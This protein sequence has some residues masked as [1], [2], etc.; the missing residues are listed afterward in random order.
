M[1]V[2][3]SR[4]WM[5]TSPTFGKG[6][7]LALIDDGCK[8]SMPEWSQPGSQVPKVLIS[9]D[10]VDG[11]DNPQHEGKGYHGSTIGIPSSVNFNGML[12][13]AF[14]DQVAVIRALE[15]CH[16]N[17]KDSVTL[18]AGL[19]WVIEHHQE[20]HITTVNLAPVDDLEHGK[21]VPTEID[22]ELKQL[23]ELRIWGYGSVLRLEAGRPQ[24]PG[25]DAGDH[26]EDWSD[27]RPSSSCRVS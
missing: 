11:D 13:V 23:R 16:C 8:L 7:T 17:V 21:P 24:P 10:S 3:S 1:Q 4:R 25:S 5:W 12:G 19:R 18:A 26:A 22:A 2:T 20:Y 9:Y 15:C 6:Q 14:N 27:L